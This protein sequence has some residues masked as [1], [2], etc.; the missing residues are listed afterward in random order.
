MRGIQRLGNT[1]GAAV[2]LTEERRGTES[3]NG[4]TSLNANLGGPVTLFDVHAAELPE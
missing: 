4:K 3:L 1:T 2:C